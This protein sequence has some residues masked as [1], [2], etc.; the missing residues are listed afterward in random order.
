MHEFTIATV[1]EGPNP[2]LSDVGAPNA[3]TRELRGKYLVPIGVAE[4]NG[5]FGLLPKLKF[6]WFIAK[7]TLGSWF[8]SGDLDGIANRFPEK[9]RLVKNAF[10]RNRTLGRRLLTIIAKYQ[11]SFM[12]QSFLLGDEGGVF[13]QLC[14]N[15]ASLCFALSLDQPK[16]EYLKVAAALDMESKLRMDGRETSPEL[17]RAWAEIGALMMNRNSQLHQDLIA[18]IEVADIPLDPRFIDRFI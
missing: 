4:V 5:S 13:D 16:P 3:M 2:V 9:E 12:D 15:L 18:D 10:R 11:K 6:G 8:S 14:H 17:Q 7:T 1:Y